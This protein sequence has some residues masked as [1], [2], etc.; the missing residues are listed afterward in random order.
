MRSFAKL[1]LLGDVL[2]LVDIIE[3][4]RRMSMREDQLDPLHYLT[5]PSLSLDSALKMTRIHLELISDPTLSLWFSEM[6]RG[7]IIFTGMRHFKANN[8]HCPDYDPS[9]PAKHLMFWD[10]NNL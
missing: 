6:M 5:L 7:G 9:L 1:Y 4:F 2:N 8:E 10:A 3:D